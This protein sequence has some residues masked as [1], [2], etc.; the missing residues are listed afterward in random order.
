MLAVPHLT[1]L[2]EKR[3]S[4]PRNLSRS[5]PRIMSFAPKVSVTCESHSTRR[6]SCS[7]GKV[8]WALMVVFVCSSPKG[9]LHDWSDFLV[10]SFLT[11]S[12]ITKL[13]AASLS[14]RAFAVIGFSSP[15]RVLS[16]VKA[17]G[18]RWT[19]FC[20]LLGWFWPWMRDAMLHKFCCQL[21]LTQPSRL[22]WNSSSSCSDSNKLA[23]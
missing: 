9:A 11:N 14:R 20:H 4:M 13:P 2:S 8:N 15:S 10:L 17:V 23:I 21:T 1:V 6:S 12:F 19:V 18:L 22:S 3:M 16:H 7:S 5:H